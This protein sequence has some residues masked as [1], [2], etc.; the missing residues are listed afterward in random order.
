[1]DFPIELDTKESDVSVLF[2]RSGIFSTFFLIKKWSTSEG[3]SEAKKSPPA[4]GRPAVD[5][6]GF[7]DTF[8]NLFLILSEP[9][10]S[11]SVFLFYR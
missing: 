11:P 5:F 3:S 9:F 10:S 2:V 7:G 8:S 1:M 4:A 6:S